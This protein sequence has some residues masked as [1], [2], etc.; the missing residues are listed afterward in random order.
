LGSQ[1]RYGLARMC[2]RTV[3]EHDLR[4]HAFVLR[5]ID[6]LSVV[7]DWIATDMARGAEAV[8]LPRDAGSAARC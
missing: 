1:A 6:A 8:R 4:K 2:T 5:K 3:S 7:I